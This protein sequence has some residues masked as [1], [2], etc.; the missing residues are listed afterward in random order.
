MFH[1]CKFKTFAN[2][3]PGSHKNKF[4]DVSLLI[5][6]V[7]FG[8]DHHGDDLRPKLA[9]YV[10]ELGF[11]SEDMGMNNDF[12]VMAKEVS[13]RVLESEN[14]LG[15]LI[16]G[17]GQG[18]AIATNR[19]QGIRAAVCNTVVDARQAREHLNANILTFGADCVEYPLAKEIVDVFLSTKFIEEERYKRRIKQVDDL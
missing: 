11:E 12:P 9:S 2:S 6:K 19:N 7:Y 13:K 1:D 16:C 14:S 5:M 8:S 17:T 10:N 15:I 3:N 18:I 4:L